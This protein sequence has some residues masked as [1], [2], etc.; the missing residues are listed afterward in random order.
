M[1][2]LEHISRLLLI[3]AVSNYYRVAIA[4]HVIGLLVISVHDRA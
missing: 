1:A 4:V 2:R 3:I